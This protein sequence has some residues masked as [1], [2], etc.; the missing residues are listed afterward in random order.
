MVNADVKV[1]ERAGGFVEE[2]RMGETE[3]RRAE[4]ALWSSVGLSPSETR[5]RRQ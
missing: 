2:V 5:G 4:T 1:R 3:Y